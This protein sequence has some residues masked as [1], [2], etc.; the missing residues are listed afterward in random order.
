[1]MP[2]DGDAN[3]T[4]LAQA[5]DW[6]RARVDV[7]A[8]CPCCTQFAKVYKRKLNGAMAYV[9]ILVSRY[10]GSDW[11]HVPSYINEQTKSPSV[12]AA[13]RGDWAKLTHWGLL[14]EL[15]GERPD[16]STRVGYYKIT[17][18]GRRFTR[19][20]LR[21][22]RHIWIYDGRSLDRKDTETVSIV[23]VLGKKF[24]YSELMSAR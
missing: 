19:D 9:L 16:G 7:G 22:P 17:E 3:R 12:A 24:N 8:A 14:E 21:V 23:E 2:F 6:L 15:A 11:I 13:V 10:D 1:V 5:K 4:T 20:Q 18:N